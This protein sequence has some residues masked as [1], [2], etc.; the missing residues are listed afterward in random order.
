MQS[1]RELETRHLIALDAVAT[2]GTF[3]RAAERL[4]YTQ[5]AVSQQIA[6]F[7]RL[8]G[9]SLFDRPGGPRPV[10][11]TP[12]GEI[13]LEHARD[14]LRRID[15]IADDVDRFRNGNAGRLDI[16]TFQSISVTVLPTVV[17]DLRREHPG[18]GVRPFESDDEEELVI[19]LLAGE[20]DLTFMV[21]PLAEG[22]DGHVLYRDPFVV[23]APLDSVGEGP[24]C[25]HR[26]VSEPMIGQHDNA[27]HRAMEAGLRAEGCNPEYVFRTNDNSAVVAMVRSG[28]GMAVMPLLAL[29]LNDTTVALRPLDPPIPERVISLVWR[30]GRTLSPAAERFIELAADAFGRLDDRRIGFEPTTRRT[31]ARAGA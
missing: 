19:K 29:D 1:F 9:G 23:V 21:G 6:A 31:P 18:L 28:M 25:V 7:E 30:K 4:G 10:E 24:M 13:M 15:A 26:L 16:G 5:S 2:E 14:V 11:L 22:L 3:G 17:H 20:L 8:V 27:C 12:L